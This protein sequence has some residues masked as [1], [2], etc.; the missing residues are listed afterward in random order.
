VS[1]DNSCLA[2]IGGILG[3]ERSGV[4][5]LHIAEV[6]ASTERAAGTTHADQPAASAQLKG[7]PEQE[8]AGREVTHP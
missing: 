2:H 4:R 5:T 8:L 7:R 6:L 1:A 3:R